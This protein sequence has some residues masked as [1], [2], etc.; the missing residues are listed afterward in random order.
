MQDF[1]IILIP[2]DKNELTYALIHKAK[3]LDAA[4]AFAEVNLVMNGGRFKEATI[5]SR[6]KSDLSYRQATDSII[7]NNNL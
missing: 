5:L 3:D 4:R 1:I 2:S 6:W 7:Y